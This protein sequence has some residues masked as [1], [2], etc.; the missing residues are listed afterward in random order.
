MISK[1]VYKELSR[2]RNGPLRREEG[3]D[4]W[5]EYLV[6]KDLVKA[7]ETAVLPGLSLQTVQWAITPPGIAALEEYEAARWAS[8]WSAFRM[9]VTAVIAAAAFI[10]SFWG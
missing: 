2:F 8:F 9:W 7:T 1:S 4:A 10:K 3:P 6:S 5:T